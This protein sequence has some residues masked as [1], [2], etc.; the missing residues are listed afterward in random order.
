MRRLTKVNKAIIFFGLV[1]TAVYFCVPS[2]NYTN[3]LSGEH[4]RQIAFEG[5]VLRKYLDKSDHSTPIAELKNYKNSI[6]KIYLFGDH[7]GLFDRIAAGDS[8]KKNKGT[9]EILKMVNGDYVNFGYV[10]FNC[11]SVKLA[12]EEYLF[13]LYDLIGITPEHGNKRTK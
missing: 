12:K 8:L 11:D 7:S 13:A 2:V 10:D 5:V 6:E 1:F 3:C 9:I 4:F